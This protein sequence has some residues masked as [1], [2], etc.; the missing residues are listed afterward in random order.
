MRLQ[1]GPVQIDQLVQDI[2]TDD[3]A[4][5]KALLTVMDL[6]GIIEIKKLYK[7]RQSFPYCT[8]V[9]LLNTDLLE[10]LKRKPE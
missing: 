9:K 8:R 2:N 5:I 4:T 1:L 6:E 10:K 7:P 3:Q